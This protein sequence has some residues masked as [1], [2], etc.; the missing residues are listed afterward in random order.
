M[1][2]GLPASLLDQLGEHQLRTAGRRRLG[3]AFAQHRLLRLRQHRQNVA[4]VEPRV[5]DVEHVHGG[6]VAHFPAIAAGAGDC[7]VAAV[8]VTEAVGAG[9]Q[10]KRGDEPFDVPLPGCRQGL[11]EVVDVEDHPALRSRKD[12]E[13]HQVGV[14]ADLD[15]EAGRRRFR[16]IGRHDAG[17]PAVKREWR[18]QHAAI[19]QRHQLLLPGRIGSAQ[20]ADRGPPDPHARASRHAHRAARGRVAACRR[21]FGPRA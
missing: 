4:V 13:I 21:P 17:R 16:Q 12:A 11:V 15:M 20:D 14:A 19:T 7:R 1:D 6:K 18:L 9:G 3:D 2:P 5:P 8:G 10:H